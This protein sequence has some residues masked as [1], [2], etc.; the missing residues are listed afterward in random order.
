MSEDGPE[1]G[2]ESEILTLSSQIH[3]SVCII[4]S[5]LKKPKATRILSERFTI[6]IVSK[7]S[8]EFRIES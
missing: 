2:H 4:N 5:H 8:N 6:I 3:K 1:K 7:R